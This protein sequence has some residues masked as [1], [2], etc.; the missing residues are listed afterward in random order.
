MIL[1]RFL[2]GVGFILTC[3]ALLTVAVITAVLVQWVM[4]G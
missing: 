1:E 4:F 3:A 2:N